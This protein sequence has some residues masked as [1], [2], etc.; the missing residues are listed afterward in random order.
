LTASTN[1]FPNTTTTVCC[2]TLTNGYTVIG[3]SACVD[4]REWNAKIGRNVAHTNAVDKIWPLEGYLLQQ[5]L[6]EGKPTKLS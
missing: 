5:K 1:V 3:S 6:F 4:P 2:L